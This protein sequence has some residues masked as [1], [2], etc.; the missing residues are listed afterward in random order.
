MLEPVT[1]GELPL[2]RYRGELLTARNLRKPTACWDCRQP[3]VR[4]E[5]AYGVFGNSMNRMQ[6]LHV[7][8]VAKALAVEA[9]A[10]LSG[11]GAAAH[12]PAGA[13]RN[14]TRT[15]RENAKTHGIKCQD[16]NAGNPKVV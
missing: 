10:R 8:C 12:K 15:K 14:V 9:A 6:R 4:G 1:A 2:V 13:R 16:G 11:N 3:I 5:V 7:A